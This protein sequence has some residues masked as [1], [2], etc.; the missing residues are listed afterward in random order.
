MTYTL[1]Y[2]SEMRKTFSDYIV[3]LIGTIGSFFSISAYI[4]NMS[5]YLNNQG[6]IGIAFIGFFAMFFLGY[7]IYLIYKH[8][9]LVIYP[10]IFED[11][12]IGFSELHKI[13]KSKTTTEHIITKLEFLCDNLSTVFTKINGH[14]I[15]VCIKFLTV[16]KER[17]LV[18]TLVRDRKSK[19]NG[20]K[21]GSSDKTKH[22]LDANTDFD[23]INSNFDDDS[24]DTS[25]YYG[26]KLPTSNYYKNTRLN[27][28]WFKENKLT[29]KIPFLENIMRRNSWPLKYRSTIVVPIVP[30]L[31]NEQK[32]ESIRGFLCI[33]SPKENTFNKQIDI[34]I[35][36]LKGVCDRIYSKMDKLN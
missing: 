21:T 10:K 17:L 34:H 36:I 14:D 19:N 5:P 16:K 31:A 30:I 8:R 27:K 18:E 3:I 1:L 35:D 12:N 7:S 33:D 22:Y 32:K 4:S 25:H 23:F 6:L 26:R 24:I 9:K 29:S 13:N 20:R 2:L 28:N 11:I 15:G